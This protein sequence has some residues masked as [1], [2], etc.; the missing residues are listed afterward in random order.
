MT[1]ANKQTSAACKHASTRVRLA[2]ARARGRIGKRACRHESK[3]SRTHARA[4]ERNETAA[5][6][7]PT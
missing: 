1:H 3:R 2:R 7:H 4:H 6:E 5:T